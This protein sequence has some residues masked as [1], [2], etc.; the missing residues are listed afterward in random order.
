V[1]KRDREAACVEIH[2]G[3]GFSAW[4]LDRPKRAE[5]PE[6][7]ARQPQPMFFNTF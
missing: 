2:D 6:M 1:E 7:P 5:I 4:V 3:A